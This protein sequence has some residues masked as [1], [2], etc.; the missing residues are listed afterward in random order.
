MADFE[1]EFNQPKTLQMQAL[2]SMLLWINVYISSLSIM[3]LR[4]LRFSLWFS[5]RVSPW[6]LGHAPIG[7]DLSKILVG[8]T[9]IL[10]GCPPK[11][12]AY[13][14]TG[15]LGSSS[16]LLSYSLCRD[17]G[18]VHCDLLPLIRIDT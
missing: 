10:G 8:Q 16:Q 14:C 17:P 13:A 18:Y 2:K 12:Y 4:G 15:L 5:T 11:V 1:N 9:K 3:M 6:M 7:I